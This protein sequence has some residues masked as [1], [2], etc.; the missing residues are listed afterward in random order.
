MSMGNV[1]PN[2]TLPGSVGPRLPPA[3][4]N[5]RLLRDRV[6]KKL[7]ISHHVYIWDHTHLVQK[8]VVA[9]PRHIHL[10]APGA[11]SIR[12]TRSEI[13]VFIPLIGC[14]RN[15]LTTH[16]LG[17]NSSITPVSSA[18]LRRW[19]HLLSPRLQLSFHL[20]PIHVGEPNIVYRTC[21]TIGEA[22]PALSDDLLP[23]GDYGWFDDD[24]GMMH[25]SFHVHTSHP[26]N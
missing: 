20:H 17:L 4:I 5:R 8:V 23:P 6:L 2:S 7:A 15:V 14:N 16:P 9:R 13:W 22:I 1:S 10:L 21:K 25:S 19:I 26:T 24:G 11:V 3:G 18:K 12:V